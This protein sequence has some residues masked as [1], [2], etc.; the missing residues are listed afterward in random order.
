MNLGHL[1]VCIRAYTLYDLPFL[2]FFFSKVLM[3]ANHA[4]D[5]AIRV[6]IHPRGVA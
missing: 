2:G 4:G 1:S 5:D 3:E 6:W